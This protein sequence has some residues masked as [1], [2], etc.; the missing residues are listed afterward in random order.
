MDLPGEND[1]SMI[2]SRKIAAKAIAPGIAG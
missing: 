2:V 1:I